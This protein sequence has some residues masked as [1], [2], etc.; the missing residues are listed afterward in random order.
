MAIQESLETHASFIFLESAHPHS[1]TSWRSVT[2]CQ[3]S[4]EKVHSD[5]TTN[6]PSV[7]KP[8]HANV[9]NKQQHKYRKLFFFLLLFLK[10]NVFRNNE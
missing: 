3:S 4:L 7:A 10:W 2:M 8:R 9:L 5:D 1:S 6:F